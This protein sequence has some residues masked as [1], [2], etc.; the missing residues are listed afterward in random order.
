M[1]RLED[2]HSRKKRERRG[3]TVTAFLTKKRRNAPLRNSRANDSVV[4]GALNRL[5]DCEFRKG[6]GPRKLCLSH[7]RLH[8]NRTHMFC[9][10]SVVSSRVFQEHDFQ[11]GVQMNFCLSHLVFSTARFWQ[12]LVVHHTTEF[13]SCQMTH[14]SS[15]SLSSH[16]SPHS[17]EDVL[18]DSF[19]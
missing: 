3:S 14:S 8:R 4:T 19:P 10:R 1:Q 5:K 11:T 13:L 9:P 7:P 16:I 18:C 2:S 17:A 6:V 12:S 15:R